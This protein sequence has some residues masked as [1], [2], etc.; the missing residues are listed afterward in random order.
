[1]ALEPQS[2]T[3]GEYT[4]TVRPLTAKKGTRAL[5]RLIANSNPTEW[6]EETLDYF[7]NLFVPNTSVEGGGLKGAPDLGAIYELHFVD[8]YYEYIQWLMF[9]IKVNFGSFF[10]KAKMQAEKN[11]AASSESE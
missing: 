6:S 2:K 1:M 7:E 10:E 9:C 5:T 4:Y 8:R 3:I 11:K